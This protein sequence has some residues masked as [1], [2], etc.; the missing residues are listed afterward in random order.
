MLLRE[1]DMPTKKINILEKKGIFTV[2]QMLYSLPKK[3]LY[4]DK[5]YPLNTEIL[6]AFLES[7]EPVAFIG[8]CKSV[9]NEYKNGKSLIK[10]RIIEKKTQN[11]LFVNIIGMYSMLNY[12][13]FME[14]KEVIVG[15]AVQYSNEYKC[16]SMLNPLVLSQEIEK[17]KTIYPVYRKYKGISDDYYRDTIKKAVCETSDV[18]YIPKALIDTYSLLTRKETVTALHLPQSKDEIENAKKRIVFED[19]LYFTCKLEQREKLKKSNSEFVIKETTVMNDL[20]SSLPFTLTDGQQTAINTMIENAKTGKR[21]SSL[22]QGDVGSGKTMVAFSLMVAMAENKYQSVL[23]A[24]TS[25]LAG[26]H[27]KELCERTEKY[28]FKAVLLTN[29]LKTKEKKTVLNMIEN[30]E[31]DFIVGTQSC[32]S[33]SVAYHNLALTITDEEHKFG[34][35]QREALV[36]KS[37]NGVHNIIMS[38]TPIPRTLANTFYGNDTDV[39]SMELPGNRKPIQT[40]V[41]TQD[42]PMFCWMLK[43]LKK[44]HQCYVVCPLIDNAEENSRMQGISSIEKTSKKYT[45]YFE[46]FGFKTGVITGATSKTEQAEIMSAFKE[47][48]I[49]ILIATTVIEVGV[50][51]PNAT[52]ITITGAERFG[53]ATLHQLRG[54]V[55][56]GE[57][58]SYC[59]L[60]KTASKETSTNLEILCNNADGLEIAK[61]DMKNRGSGNIIGSQQSGDNVYIEL[62]LKYP[63]MYNK[64]REIATNLCK[65]NTGKDIIRI[66]EEN[67]LIQ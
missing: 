36:E 45:S 3:Y 63:N 50:N 40:A 31:A 15:G 67:H 33:A 6:K 48:K 64:V 59:I 54:R 42:R 21:I 11:C 39:Y 46:Q 19:M 44:G 9:V 65:D 12:Y 41:C 13:M 22:V 17:Y 26:Q 52:V 1:T 30:G 60:Q 14:G 28:G 49:H 4:F 35:L 55:G 27:Y 62:I 66:Y 5:T 56:R 58:Q 7:K 47:N 18:D 43:E 34:V 25:V 57:F 32:I 10:I 16:F 23:M 24:P 51:N 38:G 29:E 53:L 2:E 37:S 8:T 61:A 20:I